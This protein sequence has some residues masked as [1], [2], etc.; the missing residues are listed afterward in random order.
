[1]QSIKKFPEFVS[2]NLDLKDEYCRFIGEYLPY[3]DFT[4]TNLETW[5]NQKD[6]LHF[7]NLNGNLVL[8]F[9]NV[10]DNDKITYSLIGTNDLDNTLDILSEH[11]NGDGA[12][13]KLYSIP[14]ETANLI[15]KYPVEEDRDSF[16]YIFSTNEQVRLLG[17]KFGKYRR[18][19]NHFIQ[20]N[21]EEIT[22]RELDLSNS[23]ELQWLIN[24]LH[25]WERTYEM[26]GND[27]SRIESK[28][29]DKILKNHSKFN[30]RCIAVIIQNKIESFTLFT[31]NE[32]K[33]LA[34]LHHTK[35]SYEQ[36]NIFDFTI[37]AAASK[38]KTE[39][40]DF[41]NFEQDL[42]IMGL[43]EHKTG[44]RPVKFLKK[45]TVHL[46]QPIK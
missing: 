24:S 20:D 16:D 44:L 15:T 39:D 17:T 30:L 18:K 5:L 27:E 32:S 38:L 28:A 43:R 11:L 14:E 1:M 22:I 31:V 12:E 36:R 8:R 26:G 21:G 33:K 3:C 19:I 42:G 23:E 37:Y 35:C 29:L 13:K 46:N 4:F 45:Y 7:S 10:F 6:D 40:I 2:F 25:G 34:N 41:I 9:S